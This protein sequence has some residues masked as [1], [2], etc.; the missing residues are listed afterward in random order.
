MKTKIILLATITLLFMTFCSGCEEDNQSYQ[1]KII[2]LNVG[3]CYNIIQ[4]EKSITKGLPIN[5]TITFDPSLY[6]GQLKVGDAVYFKITKYEEWT[7]IV[8]AMCVG[9][10]Y[11]G[12]LEFYNK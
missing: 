3:A 12:Q 10:Q 8:L 9:P 7:G 6:K 2:S 4:I 1:G 5:S 11:E